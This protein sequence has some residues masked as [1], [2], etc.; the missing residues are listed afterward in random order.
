MQFRL[1]DLSDT[2]RFAFQLAQ[3][4]E[5]PLAI[6]LSGTLGS[7]KTQ[8]ARYLCQALGVPAEN[9]TSPTYILLQRY[10]GDQFAIYHFDFYR[11]DNAQQVWD[12]GFDELQEGN[13]ILIIEWAEKFPETL[14]S[15]HLQ[16]HLSHSLD[17][18]PGSPTNRRFLKLV[19]TGV[20]SRS[21]AKRLASVG[22][23]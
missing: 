17:D 15:D 13:A 7:G 4:I 14:P 22:L 5:Q 2:E 23:A 9:V 1:N 18:A 12:L 11:L 10:R 8:L 20:K 3:V 6:A 16:I 19:G 21:V